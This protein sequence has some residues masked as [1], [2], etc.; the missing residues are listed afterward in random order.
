[1]R[2][3]E[4]AEDSCFA[5]TV[6]QLAADLQRLLIAPDGLLV[7]NAR[8]TNGV[9]DGIIECRRLAPA[10]MRRNDLCLASHS[11]RCQGAVTQQHLRY[12]LHFLR[13]ASISAIAHIIV[14]N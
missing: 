5:G 13:Y 12:N 3:A 7:T 8:G 6:L 11:R 4:T 14:Q 9:G 10:G 2:Q 1:M